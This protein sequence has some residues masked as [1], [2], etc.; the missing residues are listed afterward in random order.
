MQLGVLRRSRVDSSWSRTRDPRL[1]VGGLVVIVVG[2]GLLLRLIQ[3]SPDDRHGFLLYTMN[4]LTSGARYFL[5]AAGFTLIFGLMRVVNLAH[6]SL[7]LFGGYLGWSIADSATGWA[8]ANWSWVLGV[9]GAAAA[10]GLVGALLQQ[11]LLRPLQGDIY[12]LREGAAAVGVAAIAVFLALARYGNMHLWQAALFAIVAAIL[13]AAFIVREAITGPTQGRDLREALIT[14]GLSIVAA[15]LLLAEYGGLSYQFTTPDPITG[16]TNL[17]AF[18]LIYPTYLLF[19]L[20][21]AAAVGVV[22]WIMLNKTRL[23]I[24]VRAAIDDRAMVSALG[25]NIQ[26]IFALLFALGAA[27]AGIAGVVGGSA[28]SISTGEDGRYLLWSLIVVIIG[29]MGSLEGAAIGA[30]LVGLAHEYG[31]AYAP[32][33]AEIIV[34]V[35]MVAVLAIRPQGLLGRP[36]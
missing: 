17:H 26:I 11:S 12:S 19:V 30:I 3:A 18:D 32:T 36:A 29:G 22:L 28:Q 4:G 8:G 31:L 9:I 1:L 14:I 16:A 21:F 5:V 10:M 27:L 34:F 23:G 6:G 33:Y 35:L 15:D 2:I 25:I 24:I 7:Y 13:L 20:G